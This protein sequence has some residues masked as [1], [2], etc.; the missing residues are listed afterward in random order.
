MLKNKLFRDKRL[1]AVNLHYRHMHRFC[2][3][4]HIEQRQGIIKENE[5]EIRRLPFV[6]NR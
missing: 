6:F 1:G 3:E 2:K 5:Y 4:K